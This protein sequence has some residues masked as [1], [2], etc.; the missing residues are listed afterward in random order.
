MDWPSYGVKQ[1]S[2]RR[3]DTMLTTKPIHRQAMQIGATYFLASAVLG[4][5]LWFTAF[6]MGLSDS[7]HPDPMWFT[8]LSKVLLV[9]QAPVA[10]TAW[11]WQRLVPSGHFNILVMGLLAARLEPRCRLWDLFH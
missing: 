2:S 11:L 7:Y 8:F 5:L 6:G 3:C 1:R 10:C 4:V 9:L